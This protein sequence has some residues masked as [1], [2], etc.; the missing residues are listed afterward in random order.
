M[1]LVHCPGCHRRRLYGVRH[2][3]AVQN[4]PDGVIVVRLVCPCGTPHTVV[5]GRALERET[6]LPTGPG[7]RR[8]AARP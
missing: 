7:D 3:R 5:T 6:R 8:S 1:W 4:L 2:V